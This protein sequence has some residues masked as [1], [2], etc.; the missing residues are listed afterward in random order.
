ML[1]D[2]LP[3]ESLKVVLLIGS[4]LV[5]Y[6]Q[7]VVQF[8]DDEPKVELQQGGEACYHGSHTTIAV[9]EL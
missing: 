8:G 6:E 4:M 2:C 1:D 3:L 5:H 9:P 7:V